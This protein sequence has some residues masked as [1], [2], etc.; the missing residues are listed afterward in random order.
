MDPN[1]ANAVFGFFDSL[2]EKGITVDLYMHF[3]SNENIYPDG[4]NGPYHAN[5]HFKETIPIEDTNHHQYIID[6]E[7]PKVVITSS[8]SEM[9]KCNYYDKRKNDYVLYINHTAQFYAFQKLLS[10]VPK[11]Y[12]DIVF[13]W[14][15]DQVVAYEETASAIIDILNENISSP[16]IITR[17]K[18]H[19]QKYDK[20]VLAITDRWW[21]II[22]DFDP[23]LNIHQDIY[24][25]IRFN[26]QKWLEEHIKDYFK[27]LPHNIL[28]RHI[29]EGIIRPYREPY[30]RE[31]YTFLSNDDQRQEL[32]ILPL[33]YSRHYN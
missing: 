17:P 10:V 3:W 12:Y 2:R 13:R 15:Y 22:G 29:Y 23:F 27:Y 21:G 1:T 25:R 24:K 31:D 4:Y 14:R 33:G 8:F 28:Y 5:N 18:Y 11:N 6:R 26:N 19:M 30:I 20:K 9:E 32:G 16:S 7:N